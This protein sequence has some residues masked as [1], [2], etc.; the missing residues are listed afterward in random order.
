MIL[1]NQMIFAKLDK[2][3]VRKSIEL[4]PDQVRQ[5]LSDAELIKI[6]RDYSS[7]NKVVINGMGGSNLGA[8]VIKA[9]LAGELKV[10]III[11]PGYD[12]PAFVDRD[13]LYVISSYSGTTEEPISTYRE[14]KKRGAKIMAI[15]SDIPKA[16]LYEL[17][18][19]E[20]IPGYVFKPEY[21][22]SGQ[23]RLGT[24]YSI[25]GLMA[26]LAKVDLYKIKV[27]DVENIIAEMEIRT[28]GMR[29][30]EPT[31]DNKAKKLAEKIMGRIPVLIG[32]EFLAGNLHIMRNQINESAKQFS[33]FLILPDLN[34]Y[35]MEGL[36][37]PE[38]N[39][40]N[41]IFVFFNSKLYDKRVQKRVLLTQDVVEKNKVNVINYELTGKNKLSQSFEML[42]LGSWISY[43]LGILNDVD[44]VKIPWVDWFKEQL[45]IFLKKY[46]DDRLFK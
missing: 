20:N 25:F 46:Q 45:K 10:P 34:H 31:T 7:I 37:L 15:T 9:V 2:Y 14:A 38:E 32:A 36:S 24:G 4:L 23:P 41:I 22:P 40:D 27:K 11:E 3:N 30:E 29:T 19:K 43:Y 28:R 12:V 18:I 42:Q 39:K 44:P 26:L 8:H 6:P 1:D 21:N 17:M 5:V 16:K 33:T 35:A 13:T